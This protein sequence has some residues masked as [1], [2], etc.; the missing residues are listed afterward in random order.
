MKRFIKNI[1]I[2]LLIVA[3]VL[4]LARNPLARLI[5]P[6][7]I[8][9]AWGVPAEVQTV[10]VGLTHADVR[11]KGLQIMNPPGFSAEPMLDVPEAYV[12]YDLPA[13]LKN[14][15]HLPEVRL[16]ITT[17]LVERNAHGALN[18]DVL[19][20][21]Q[22]GGGEPA[23][24]P[25]RTIEINRVKL[26]IGTVVYRDMTANPPRVLKIPVNLDEDIPNIQDQRQLAQYIVVRA[27]MNTSL[28]ALLNMDVRTLGTTVKD[29]LKTTGKQEIND[30]LNKAAD[31][32]K[33]M[34]K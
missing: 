2:L 20:T 1:I 9:R 18:I 32:L 7:T 13:L 11:V 8:T 21:G 15:I 34:L 14:K 4:V 5:L 28:Q 19:K 16:T 29:L 31:S 10:A 3:A 30:A 22:P 6:Q 17:L 25:A 27:L 23:P 33:K 24:G 12:A 26:S